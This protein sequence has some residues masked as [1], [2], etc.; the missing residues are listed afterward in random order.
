MPLTLAELRDYQADA[1]ADDVDI[2]LERMQHWTEE[3][4]RAY[5]ESGGTVEPPPPKASLTASVTTTLELLEALG[6]VH[7]EDEMSRSP[8]APVTLSKLQA[9]GLN[10]RITLLDSFAK[11]GVKHLAER[12]KLAEAVEDGLTRGFIKPAADERAPYNYSP[13]PVRVSAP[14]LSP[15]VHVLSPAMSPPVMVLRPSETQ[16]QDIS[17]LSLEGFKGPPL[18]VSFYSG[19]LNAFDGRKILRRWLAAAKL[20]GFDEG[21]LVLDGPMEYEES[22]TTYHEFVAALIAKVNQADPAKT[23]PILLVGHSRGAM[24]AFAL[25]HALGP[26]VKKLY[27]VACRPPLPPAGAFSLNDA[28]GVGL[29]DEGR[30][31]LSRLS[32]EKVLTGLRSW[33]NEM[34][35]RWLDSPRAEWPG[36][37]AETVARVRREYSSPV[38]A[39]MPLVPLSVPILG[40]AAADEGPKGETAQKMEGWKAMTTKGFELKVLEGLGHFNILQPVRA[41][42]GTTTPLYDALLCDMTGR[43]SGSFLRPPI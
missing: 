29:S 18:L 23:R 19:G 41:I 13:A 38:L 15:P 35:T 10:G 14:P 9:W 25:A 33:E 20:A 1:L 21:G 7:L 31:Q 37:V 43:P 27:V 22:C 42:D 6:M 17:E 40:V 34:L 39:T 24:S 32:D 4:A 5:F 28:W 2:D 30:Q 36:A 26:R 3:Q 8:L 16:L 11:A 12:K